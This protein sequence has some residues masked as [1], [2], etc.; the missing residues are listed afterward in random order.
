MKRVVL[1][2][3]GLT[4]ALTSALAM[5]QGSPESLLPP[6]FEKPKARPATPAPAPAMRRV[7]LEVA[8]QGLA[9]VSLRLEV[10]ASRPGSLQQALVL[11]LLPSL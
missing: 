6:G 4:L 7:V 10:S 5:A 1:Y 8:S 11:L 2:T 9:L 3:T